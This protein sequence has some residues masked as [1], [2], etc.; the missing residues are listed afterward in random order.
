MEFTLGHILVMPSLQ[1]LH[2]DWC[3]LS[4]SWISKLHGLFLHSGESLIKMSLKNFYFKK[5][6]LVQVLSSTPSLM[7]LLL[8]PDHGE[9]YMITDYT[10]RCLVLHPAKVG[11]PSLLSALEVLVLGG[12]LNFSDI[13]LENVV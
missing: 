9:A 2:L 12:A 10:L 6:V 7:E 11:P 5:E 4:L 13:Q 1:E 8:Q 3:G